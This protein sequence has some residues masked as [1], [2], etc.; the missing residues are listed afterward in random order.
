MVDGGSHGCPIHLLIILILEEE[1]GVL[2]QNSNC[3][4]MC[5][6]D[7][8]VLRLSVLF[9]LVP[10]DG[11]GMVHWDWY[12]EGLYFMGCSAYHFPKADGFDLVYRVLDILDVMGDVLP[13]VW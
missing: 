4:M 8:D 12:E 6:I 13:M 11:Y 3:V 1:I 7:M 2:G 5:C 10:H 9:Q